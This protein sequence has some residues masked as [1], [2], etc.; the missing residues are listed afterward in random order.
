M[1]KYCTVA[2]VLAH[3]YIRETGLGQKKVHLMEIQVLA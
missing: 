3:T 1:R 2:H